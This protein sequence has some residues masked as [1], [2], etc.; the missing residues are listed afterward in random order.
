MDRIKE[1]MI[2]NELINKDKKYEEDDQET[3]D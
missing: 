2:D 3:L 1:T